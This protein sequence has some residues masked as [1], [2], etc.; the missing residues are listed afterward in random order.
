M[1]RFTF[2]AAVLGLGLLAG[3]DAGSAPGTTRMLGSVE[4]ETAFRTARTVLARHFSVETAEP[5]TG[6]ITTRPEEIENRPAGLIGITQGQTRQVATLRVQRAGG[7]VMARL[8][9]AVQTLGNPGVRRQVFGTGDN[10]DSVPNQSPSE[11]EAA[12][13]TEQN[14][15]WATRRFDARRE[16]DI[17][18][19]IFGELNPAASQPAASA[20]PPASQPAK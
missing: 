11:M 1:A 15:E 13:T 14:E 19:E 18:N 17:L 9:I 10:Y 4:Y 6:V 8:A 5:T 20:P 16:A 12:T 7:Q 2:F 3:C